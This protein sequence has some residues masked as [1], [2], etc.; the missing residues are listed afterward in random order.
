M[1]DHVT[2]VDFH[3]ISRPEPLRISAAIKASNPR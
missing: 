2:L 1:Y 3:E